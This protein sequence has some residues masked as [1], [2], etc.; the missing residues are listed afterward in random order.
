MSITPPAISF[1]RTAGRLSPTKVAEGTYLVHQVVDLAGLPI[2]LYN[3]AAVIRA[4]QPVLV[5][6][7]S[8]HNRAQWLRDVFGL[9]DPSELRWVFVSHADPDHTGNLEAVLEACPNARLVCH[10]LLAESVPSIVSADALHWADASSGVATTFN[11][12]DREM[13]VI[14]PPWYDTPSTMGLLD[15][16][17]GAYWSADAFFCL[18][19]GGEA[20][21]NLPRDVSELD[22][23]QWSQS[24]AVAASGVAPWLTLVDDDRFADEVQRVADLDISV[25]LP[26]HSPAISGNAVADTLADLPKQPAKCRTAPGLAAYIGQIVAGEQAQEHPGQ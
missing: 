8:R 5:D 6:T 10:P 11:A 22:G 4:D 16:K 23:D 26:A 9:L 17:T 14:R 18:V 12:G 1:V 7:G 19:P 21:D 24:M 13:V 25:I 3:N 20:V 2:S 15:T